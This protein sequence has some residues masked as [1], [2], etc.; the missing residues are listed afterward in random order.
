MNKLSFAL[1][2]VTILGVSTPAFANE[3]LG[4]LNA[5]PE[6]Y[7]QGL[8]EEQALTQEDATAQRWGRG[9]R[10]WGRGGRGGWGGGWGRGPGWGGGWGR[11]CFAQDGYGRSYNNVR[12]CMNFSGAPYSCRRVCW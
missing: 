6:S 7:A 3:E 4:N 9:G 11:R 2:A 1:T 5:A 12:Q 10:G 8:N